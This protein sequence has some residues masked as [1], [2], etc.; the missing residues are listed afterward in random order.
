[1]IDCWW[2]TFEKARVPLN[3]VMDIILEYLDFSPTS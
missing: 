1:M 2:S 3:L